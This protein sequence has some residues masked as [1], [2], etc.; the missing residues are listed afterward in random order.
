MLHLGSVCETVHMALTELCKAEG[1]H[2]GRCSDEPAVAD[3]MGWVNVATERRSEIPLRVKSSTIGHS[4]YR[5]SASSVSM[6]SRS[7]PRIRSP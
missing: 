5:S 4:I 1:L 3:A 2:I 6:F 7:L